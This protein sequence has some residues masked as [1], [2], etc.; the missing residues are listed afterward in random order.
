MTEKLAGHGAVVFMLSVV[1][2]AHPGGAASSPRRPVGLRGVYP[3]RFEQ[4]HGDP[5]L[6]QSAVFGPV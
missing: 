2:S 1:F 3:I 5:R 6:R 4:L